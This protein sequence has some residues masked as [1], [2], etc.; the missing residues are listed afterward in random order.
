M[1]HDDNIDELLIRYITNEATSAESAYVSKWI[2]SHP[3]N[4]QHFAQ[5]YELWHQALVT[6]YASINTDQAYEEFRKQHLSKPVINKSNLFYS[7]F[8]FAALLILAFGIWIFSARKFPTEGEVKLVASKGKSRVFKLSDGTKIWLNGG[9]VLTVAKG[10]NAVNR[11]V[12]LS[13]EAFFEIEGKKSK[14]PFLVRTNKYAIRDIGTQFNIKA[15]PEDD[16]FEASVVQGEI[17]IENGLSKN[18]EY[19]RIYL[20]A[21]QVLSASSDRSKNADTKLEQPDG[22]FQKIRIVQIQPEQQVNF[23]G[24]KNDVLAFDGNSLE[25]IAK[26]LD[27]RFGTVIVIEKERL[28]QIRYSGTFKHAR[29]ATEIL[30][31][32]KETTEINYHQNVNNITIGG[33]GL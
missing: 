31:V 26:T 33:V 3:E 21:H 14:L 18:N 6:D 4:E 13:G 17:S 28:K 16:T 11:T 1:M 23:V 30:E 5:L 8:A 12:S 25:E 7:G 2:N 27:R 29:S 32:I 24:W 20:K 22:R 9:S 15:Y 19:N 10:F